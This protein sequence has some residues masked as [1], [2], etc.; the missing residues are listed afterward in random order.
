MLEV[1][2]I[3]FLLI[4][5]I[6]LVGLLLRCRTLALL[7]TAIEVVRLDLKVLFVVLGCGRRLTLG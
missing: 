1:L 3:H 2:I 6:F 7:A 4:F 5:W